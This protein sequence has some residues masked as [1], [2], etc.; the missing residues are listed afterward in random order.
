MNHSQGNLITRS[1]SALLRRLGR[2]PQPT[3][4]ALV[5]V[6]NEFSLIGPCIGNLRAIGVTE[7]VVHDVASTDGTREWVAAQPDV[8]LIET[9]DDD[10]NEVMEQRAMNA[11]L[12]MRSDWLIGMDADEFPLPKAG[13]LRA[14]L[15][16]TKADVLKIPRYN[17]VL[18]DQGLRMPLPPHPGAYAQTDLYIQVDRNFRKKLQ[19]NPTL[20]WLQFAPD[21]KIIFRLDRLRNGDIAGFTDGLHNVVAAEGATVVTETATDIVTA[22][23]GLSDYDRFARKVAHIQSLIAGGIASNFGWTWRRWAAQADEGTLRDE[24][25]RSVV[26]EPEIAA[27]RASGVIASA[28]DLL[29][30]KPDAPG[31]ET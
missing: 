7:I 11:V 4:A 2:K 31:S 6:K 21:S 29:E 18:S 14:C 30:Q 25:D 9:R 27:L 10:S 5:G 15:A 26:G 13:D 20:T 12:A 28:A 22:H 23:V 16:A 1:L 17:V 19:S 3:I 24:Y 8:Q